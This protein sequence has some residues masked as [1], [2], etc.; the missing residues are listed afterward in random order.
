MPEDG[1]RMDRVAHVWGCVLQNGMTGSVMLFDPD[2]W[3]HAK[4]E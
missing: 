2:P 1:V 4:F 3:S